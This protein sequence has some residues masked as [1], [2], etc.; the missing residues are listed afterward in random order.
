M[1]SK[2][3]Y[4]TIARGQ[5]LADSSGL[6]DGIQ[7]IRDRMQEDDGD[8]ILFLGASQVA[9]GAE[10]DLQARRIVEE[11]LE[12]F[13]ES[14][15]LRF[16]L[17]A[18]LERLE[19]YAAAEGAFKIVLEKNPDHADTLNY[20]GYMLAE[21]GERLDEALRYVEKAV[22]LDPY[23]G[24]YLDSLGWVYYQQNKLDLAEEFL[25]KAARIN[26]T[27]ATI[28]E[29][30]GDLYR[31]KGDLAKARLYYGKSVR[32]AKEEE[33]DDADRVKKKLESLSG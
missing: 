18:V 26:R 29:H 22:E 10:D 12:R 13:P 20:L 2:D 28:L 31:K 6:S 9:M 30:L 7:F 14:E 33:R 4:V 3:P 25:S 19:E 8:E 17:G 16:Q 15:I 11:S 32:N 5:A 24:A 23:N 1:D 21:R 27:D